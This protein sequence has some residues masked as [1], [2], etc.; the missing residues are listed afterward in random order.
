ML[1]IT[2]LTAYTAATITAPV[3]PICANCKHWRQEADGIVGVCE[4]EQFAAAVW[5]KHDEGSPILTIPDFYCP[6]VE[7]NE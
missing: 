3:V 1:D 7:A 4:S 5:A 6:Y 2:P